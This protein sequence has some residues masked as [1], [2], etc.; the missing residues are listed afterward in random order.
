MVSLLGKLVAVAAKTKPVNQHQP[1]F[2][3]PTM[4]EKMEKIAAA[5][6]NAPSLKRA[7]PNPQLP[8][9]ISGSL[10][11]SDVKLVFNT[12]DVRFGHFFFSDHTKPPHIIFTRFTFISL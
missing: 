12:S 1:N 5:D 10:S 9:W 4:W 6:T 2:V 8:Y 3:G 11:P 7:I